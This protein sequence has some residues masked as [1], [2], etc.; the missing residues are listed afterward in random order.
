LVNAAIPPGAIREACAPTPEAARHLAA[1]V[2]GW[3]LSAR[4]FDR[5]LRVARTIADL[6]GK[7]Q[8]EIDDVIRATGFR[9]LD[10]GLS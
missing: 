3:E 10:Q 4:A 1:L 9:V 8:L 7:E 6:G 2:E 5:L